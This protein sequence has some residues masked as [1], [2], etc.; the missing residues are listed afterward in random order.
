MKAIRWW[1]MLATTTV[2]QAGTYLHID[3][4]LWQEEATLQDDASDDA[5]SSNN[6]IIVQKAMKDQC[7]QR[8]K[9]FG[10][11]MYEMML[12]GWTSSHAPTP[13]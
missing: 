1:A 11:S 3:A 6:H 4:E 10:W 12:D 13:S 2:A 5:N 7:L 8:S 9:H